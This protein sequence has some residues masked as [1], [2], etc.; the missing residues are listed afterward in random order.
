MD[1]D[2]VSVMISPLSYGFKN[3]FFVFILRKYRR[4]TFITVLCFGR[5]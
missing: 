1:V 3:I 5:F 4:T 2:T